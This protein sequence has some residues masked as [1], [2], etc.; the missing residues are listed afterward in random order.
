MSLIEEDGKNSLYSN[1]AGQCLGFLRLVKT[2]QVHYS[3]ML[4]LKWVFQANEKYRCVS[5]YIPNHA[6]IAQKGLF[7]YSLAQ[8][9]SGD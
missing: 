2:N 4:I 1:I 6:I 7:F 8:K 5:E 3:Y 9:M